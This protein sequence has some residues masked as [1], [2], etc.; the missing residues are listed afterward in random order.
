MKT[1]I[2]L[3]QHF[4]SISHVN[5]TSFSFTEAFCNNETWLEAVVI[6]K[7]LVVIL[8][9]ARINRE[10]I[11]FYINVKVLCSLIIRSSSIHMCSAI[12]KPGPIKRVDVAEEIAH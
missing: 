5:Y 12:D 10:I 7:L 6:V 1:H 9:E 2:V 11:S 4:V 8:N 3:T